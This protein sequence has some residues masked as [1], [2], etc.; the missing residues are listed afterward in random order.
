ML[1]KGRSGMS[2]TLKSDIKL[3]DR[4]RDP[5]TGLEGV[6]TSVTFYLHACERVTLEFVKEGELKWES[7]DAPR[8]VHIE[9]QTQPRTTRTGGPGGREARPA[10][11]GD[12]R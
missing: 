1:R 3:G 7:F 12:R 6:A 11:T 2:V 8:L 5:L 10:R 9:S 4:Y